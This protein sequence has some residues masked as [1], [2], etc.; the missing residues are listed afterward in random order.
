MAG[1]AYVGFN[2]LK[3]KFKPKGRE[4]DKDSERD[5]EARRKEVN[6]ETEWRKYGRDH[7]PSNGPLFS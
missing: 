1:Q 2:G 6:K 7:M 5:T 3:S 4:S